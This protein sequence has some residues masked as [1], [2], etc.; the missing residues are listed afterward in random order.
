MPAA[1]SLAVAAAAWRQRSVSGGSTIN[2][3]LKAVAATATETARMKATMTTMINTK[4][5]VAVAAAAARRQHGEQC[6]RIAAAAAAALLQ[7]S[8]GSAAA[9]AAAKGCGWLTSKK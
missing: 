2:N 1:T 5:T 9:A 6:G 4:A 7:C 3:Q 8:G